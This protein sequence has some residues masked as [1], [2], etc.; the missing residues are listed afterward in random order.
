M[1]APRPPR[2]RAEGIGSAVHDLGLVACAVEV[3]KADDVPQFVKGDGL[4]VVLGRDEATPAV[5]AVEDDVRLEHRAIRPRVFGT[6]TARV[7]FAPRSDQYT[8]LI[9]SPRRGFLGASAE[10]SNINWPELVHVFAA[11]RTILLHPSLPVTTTNLQTGFWCDRQYPNV[12]AKSLALLTAPLLVTTRSLPLDAERGYPASSTGTSQ[13][14]RLFHH[15][16][17]VP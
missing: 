13:T 15:S 5:V 17:T 3:A 4:H 12:T 6:V 7:P 1:P 11:A 9:P 2:L 10:Y 16:K 8:S 14:I